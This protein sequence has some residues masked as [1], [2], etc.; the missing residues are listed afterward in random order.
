MK[1][2]YIDFEGFKM[3][4]IIIYFGIFTNEDKI[5]ITK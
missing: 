2:I 1:L 3:N 5:F 4:V